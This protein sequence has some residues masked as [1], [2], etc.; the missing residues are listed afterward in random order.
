[1]MTHFMRD[2]IG[3][4][5]ITRRTMSTLEIT[6]KGKIDID[7]LVRRAVKRPHG[8][9]GHAAGGAYRAAKQHQVRLFIFIAG[10]AKNL[11]PGIFS[12][13]QHHGNKF[14]LLLLF[15]CGLVVGFNG[16][17]RTT[18]LQLQ[19]YLWVDTQ[20][21]G[22][23]QGND[24]GTNPAFKSPAAAHPSTT[25][26]LDIR[27]PAPSFPPH[28]DPLKAHNKRY[29][30]VQNRALPETIRETDRETVREMTV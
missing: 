26:I 4:C 1:M 11:A 10:L 24:N 12:V 3:L 18:L 27:A 14:S 17:R 23:R 19:Q 22:Q 21:I 8:G 20:K 29:S 15:G 2:H 7:L 16:L 5:K 30:I 6:E 13:R 28:N 9:T 25:P